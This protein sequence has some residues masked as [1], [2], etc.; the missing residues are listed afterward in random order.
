MITVMN[1]EALLKQNLAVC[2]P[3]FAPPLT[4][5]NC[6]GMDLS[7]SSQEF[8]GLGE[9]ELDR[10]IAAAVEKGAEVSRDAYVFPNWDAN[11]DYGEAQYAEL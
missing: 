2:A 11:V 1:F 7:S 8:A 9:G 4:P 3:I 10:A 5:A 6:T